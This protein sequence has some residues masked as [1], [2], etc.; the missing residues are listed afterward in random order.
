MADLT[1]YSFLDVA[2]NIGGVLVDRLWEGDDAVMIEPHADVATPMIGVDG[3][4]LVSISADRAATITVKLQP[5]SSMHASMLKRYADMQR[6]LF[7]SFSIAITDVRNG[8][9]GSCGECVILAKPS[10]QYGGTAT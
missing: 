8:S 7:R 2:A 10:D 9:G 3:T 4:P 1:T 5:T 6:G